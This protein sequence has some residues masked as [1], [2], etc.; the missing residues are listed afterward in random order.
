MNEHPYRA[1]EPS[2]EADPFRDEKQERINSLVEE[3]E[4]LKAT[5]LALSR[6]V[7]KLSNTRDPRPLGAPT[8][9]VAELSSLR[10]EVAQL[11]AAQSPAVAPDDP[12]SFFPDARARSILTQA[13]RDGIGPRLLHLQ[14]EAAELIVAA[15]HWRRARPNAIT[16]FARELVDVQLMIESFRYAS[17]PPT[18]AQEI[19]K[20]RVEKILKLE[21]ILLN[22]K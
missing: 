10:L 14:E 8:W 13:A 21:T 3:T 15:A 18:L 9:P 5:N 2:P 7:E 16:E 20:A 6:L 1:P 11:K 12:Y 4:Q 17:P 19:R 22:R